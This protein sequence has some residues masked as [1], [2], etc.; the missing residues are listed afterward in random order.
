MCLVGGSRGRFTRSARVLSMAGLLWGDAGP[1][2]A[3]QVAA[4]GDVR[5]AS[6]ALA[7]SA[8]TIDGTLDEPAWSE[9]E[10]IGA[11]VQR[12]P[13]PGEAPTERTEV[14]LLYDPIGSL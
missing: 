10:P 5:A 6:V 9:A 4:G 2:A 1:A 7:Q 14:R 13:D 11:L 3:G 8:V 12:Q